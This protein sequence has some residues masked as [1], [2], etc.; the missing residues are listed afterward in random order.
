MISI[1]IPTLNEEKFLPSL[2]SSL[3]E[4]SKKVFEIVV[5]DGSSKD[6]TVAIAQSFASD[7]PKL[8]VIV[9][10][11][12]NLPRQRN[13]GA[14]ATT[15]EWLVFIDADSVVFPHFIERISTYIHE[16]HPSFFTTWA[17]PDSEHPGDA[18]I[19]LLANMLL[20]TSIV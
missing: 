6:K 11:K 10:Q 19:T 17:R 18:N 2:L 9:G 4:Q 12:A 14:K 20:E 8:Q 5:V 7:L 3:V 15:G 1:V 16:A 13:I